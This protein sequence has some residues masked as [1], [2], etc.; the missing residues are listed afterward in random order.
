ME[1]WSEGLT[2]NF[3]AWI[4][5]E[6]DARALE[7][8]YLMHGVEPVVNDCINQFNRGVVSRAFMQEAIIMGMHRLIVD[9]RAFVEL[10][11]LVERRLGAIWFDF[12][13]EVEESFLYSDVEEGFESYKIL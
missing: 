4:F 11:D 6:E 8:L 5:E 12:M 13:K 10:Y 2:E 3:K 7:M 9:D 1:K